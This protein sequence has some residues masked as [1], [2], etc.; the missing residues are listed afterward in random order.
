MGAVITAL[1]FA[2]LESFNI[3]NILIQ[4]LSQHPLLL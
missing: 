4:K 1:I 3:S 2:I